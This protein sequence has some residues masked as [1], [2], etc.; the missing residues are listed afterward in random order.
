MITL[1]S[2]KKCKLKNKAQFG[3][4]TDS[5]NKIVSDNTKVS[6]NLL[7]NQPVYTKEEYKEEYEKYLL[8]Q[9]ILNQK[10]YEIT[11]YKEP[12]LKQKAL[13]VKHAI[14]NPITTLRNNSGDQNV[15]D[16]RASIDYALDFV[17]PMAYANAIYNTGN[18]LLHPVKTG[19]KIAKKIANTL[20][21]ATQYVV[22]GKNDFDVM[23]G[24]GVM[25]DLGMSRFP[26][27]EITKR[28]PI[29][30]II[31]DK[32]YTIKYHIPIKKYNNYVKSLHA[33][34]NN[35]ET[36]KRLTNAGINPDDFF[37]NLKNTEFTSKP[38]G[39]SLL[40]FSPRIDKTHIL[41]VDFKQLDKLKKEGYNLDMKSIV[42]H[43]IG[44]LMQSRKHYKYND[45][46]TKPTILDIETDL[47]KTI[48]PQNLNSIK[49]IEDLDYFITANRSRLSKNRMKGDNT[50]EDHQKV[51]RLPFLRELKRELIN[52]KLIKN[53]NDKIT[54]EILYNF[55]NK[56]TGNR[57]MGF[58]NTDKE[59][60]DFLA[61]LLNKTPMFAGAIGGASVLEN[62]ISEKNKEKYPY[63]GIYN[64]YNSL[65]NKDSNYD[66][67]IN[68]LINTYAFG[69]TD[70]Y[71]YNKPIK[72]YDEIYDL[73][74]NLK[75]KEF[76]FEEQTLNK[77]WTNFANAW[78]LGTNTL[79]GLGQ[80]LYNN[81][82]M[83][84]KAKISQR[85]YREEPFTRYNNFNNFYN[86]LN[87]Q[88]M[89]DGGTVSG[90]ELLELAQ[91][92]DID[93][94]DFIEKRNLFY[95]NE[96]QSEDNDLNV[97]NDSNNE[98]L[99]NDEIYT[100]VNNIDSDN[101]TKSNKFNISTGKKRAKAFDYRGDPE[102]MNAFSKLLKEQTDLGNIKPAEMFYDPIKLNYNHKRGYLNTPIGKHSNHGHFATENYDE[103]LKVI[104]LAKSMGLEI[105]E[106]GVED[107]IDPVHTD[108][109]YH[110][111]IFEKGGIVD[112]EGY[113]MSNI[114]NFTPKK[115]INSNY[116]DTN[117]MSVPA[118]NANG[119]ILYNNTG[120][121]YIPGKKVVEYPIFAQNGGVKK[122][123][124]TI[125]L[126]NDMYGNPIVADNIYLNTYDDRS[127]R[128]P[129][130]EPDDTH[131]DIFLGQDAFP[132]GRYDPKAIAHENYHALQAKTGNNIIYNNFY[133]RPNSYTSSDLDY[134]DYF[135]KTMRNATDKQHKYKKF[136]KNNPSFN[137]F[138]SEDVNSMLYNK[139]HN[140]F[141]DSKHPYYGV[142][143]DPNTLEGAAY[144]YEHN[145]TNYNDFNNT[146][147]QYENG[148]IVK[149]PSGKI[150][151]IK[152]KAQSGKLVLDPKIKK[153][154]EDA[155]NY[156]YQIINNNDYYKLP[157]SFTSKITD[158]SQLHGACISG[159]CGP[160]SKAGI[161]FKGNNLDSQIIDNRFMSNTDFAKNAELNNFGKPR[162]LENDLIP[163]DI[164]QFKTGKYGQ[165]THAIQILSNDGTNIE[166]FDNY[167]KKKGVKTVNEFNE[168]LRTGK[169]QYFRY[170]SP[171]GGRGISNDPK[172][173]EII[174]NKNKKLKEEGYTFNEFKNES[175]YYN[176]E[177]SDKNNI[178]QKILKMSIDDNVVTE[179]AKKYNLTKKQVQNQI[180][181]LP[182]VF[183]QESNYGNPSILESP[184]SF[185]E[186]KYE[187]IQPSYFTSDNSVG[188]AQIKYESIPKDLRD[189]YNIKS[190]KDL[191]NSEIFIP[192]TLEQNLRN[193]NWVNK[194]KEKFK[195]QG[196]TSLNINEDNIDE[197]SLYARQQFPTLNGNRKFNPTYQ[198]IQD[199]RKKYKN[200]S[201]LINNTDLDKISDEELWEKVKDTK[202]F[203]DRLKHYQLNLD[204]GS[205]PKQIIKYSNNI[206]K[207]NK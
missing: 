112:N 5:R 152:N 49:N 173:Q 69:L 12:T 4:I 190:S 172:I 183:E 206:F 6:K 122:P 97:E 20:A 93:N 43:E 40:N 76:A 13:A 202:E 142:Y 115:I 104:E 169:G 134:Y 131:S 60:Y 198:A 31:D 63:G 147:Y 188:P 33:E 201:P 107:E 151:K 42:D 103:M 59:N 130:N 77:G 100:K 138:S 29:K 16:D 129:V 71:I 99:E 36:I 111:R 26:L 153:I 21:G 176:T 45:F 18:D 189:K 157:E 127:F 50:A 195:K 70:N 22:D 58:T 44:H 207:K 167:N 1:P 106:D 199:Y 95:G 101:Q 174:D 205:Y 113:R 150:V 66:N 48:S 96:I 187:N 25:W 10:K 178:I 17:N 94:P 180:A 158:K 62:Q 108:N 23:P 57:I 7:L 65:F 125:N 200:S 144:Y 39:S 87:S 119:Q 88:Y 143:S 81:K 171:V 52:S 196:I 78:E 203:K 137:M 73:N 193:R 155:V 156:A 139:I 121:H 149:L 141:I 11:S 8:Q 191:Y 128:L 175:D 54:P 2:G 165:P 51:E 177:N 160:Y 163:A 79:F 182:G 170:G 37:E 132:N 136:I 168:L 124:F 197:F 148:G 181:L 186:Q 135:N 30:N 204:P 109:S 28:V 90:L 91:N 179:M 55:K 114:K 80:D 164:F 146:N 140:K 14:E 92:N 166:Y 64:Q 194:N 83:K 98:N 56:N 41:N 38:V 120:T 145:G 123:D 27:K 89:E 82:L 117:N 126:E 15:S 118:I 3:K 105:R 162:T 116:I 161:T 184:L 75:S 85:N 159:V 86:P 61:D 34:L 9:A 68:N 47:L 154:R 24:L 102:K 84:E 192:L 32:L 46:Y 19:K 35:P 67:T 53:T 72:K 110:Y 133:K 185:F 74:G